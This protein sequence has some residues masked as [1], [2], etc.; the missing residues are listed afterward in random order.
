MKKS[1]IAA[2]AASVAL[3]AMPVVGAFA[4]NTATDTVQITVQAACAIAATNANPGT[5]TDD[6]TPGAAA[7]S[8]SGSTFEITCNDTG[9]WY[10]KAAGNGSSTTKTNMHLS[11]AEGET[12]DIQTGT[13][14][15]GG[16]SA[17]GFKFTSTGGTVAN[18]Y[19]GA[20]GTWAA[21]PL[22][23]ANQTVVSHANAVSLGDSKDT[24]SVTYGVYA[25][26]SQKTGTYTGVVLYTLGSPFSGS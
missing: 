9:G 3:A 1:I 19:D 21:I 7:T 24:V 17:W 12:D 2:S 14:L 10:L 15:S 13:T 23:S 18:G 11:G 5:Y 4:A 20:N 22:S 25:K 16:N 6:I 8:I 26:E